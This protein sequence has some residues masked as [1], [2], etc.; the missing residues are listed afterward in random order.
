MSKKYDDYFSAPQMFSDETYVLHGNLTTEEVIKQMNGDVGLNIDVSQIK[1]GLVRFGF[2]PESVADREGL[3]CPCWYTG[4]D[5]GRGS[6]EV[7]IVE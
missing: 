3:C 6:K 4:A 7:W 5:T 1:R 2:P